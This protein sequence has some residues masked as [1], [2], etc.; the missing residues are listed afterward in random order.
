MR[1]FKQVP[2]WKKDKK[3]GRYIFDEKFYLY[4]KELSLKA[5]G[6]LSVLLANKNRNSKQQLMN[7]AKDGRES[8]DNGIKELEEKGYLRIK[9]K[10]CKGQFYIFESSPTCE[11]SK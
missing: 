3:M 11:F 2:A 1:Q 4:D 7:Y 10:N 5:K 6:I 9:R 8:I